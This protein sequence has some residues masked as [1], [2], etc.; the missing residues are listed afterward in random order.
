M[1]II[2]L[3]LNPAF[4]IHCFVDDFKPFRENLARVTS[5]D[6]GGKGVNIS[7]ALCSYGVES[8]ALVTLGRENGTDFARS[9]EASG[10]NFKA[11]T[12]EGRIRENI[13]VHTLGNDETRISFAGFNTDNSL[14]CEYEKILDEMCMKNAT[15]TLTGSNPSGVSVDCV[16]ALLKKLKAKGARIVIDSKSFS[17]DDMIEVAPFLI[18]PNEEE[19][20]EYMKKPYENINDA[21]TFALDM[22]AKGVENVM[23]SLGAKGALLAAEDGVFLCTPPK[24]NAISTIGAGDST[25]AGFIS[26]AYITENGGERLRRA[27]AFGSA[28][29]LTEGTLPPRKEDIENILSTVKVEKIK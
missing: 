29:C 3:T 12:V 24:I 1:N 17:L 9:L 19:I 14:I 21:L 20:S 16:K 5:R 23:V 4:D 18:K 11:V 13:T 25:I 8:L 6:A 28:A 15:V 7:R 22:R 10:V 2:T 26:A 27:V